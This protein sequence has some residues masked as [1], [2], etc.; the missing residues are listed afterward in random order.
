[1]LL[2]IFHNNKLFQVTSFSKVF[3][4]VFIVDLTAKFLNLREPSAEM[5]ALRP[6]NEPG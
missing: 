2:F 1:M 4:T 3:L 5:K 6:R